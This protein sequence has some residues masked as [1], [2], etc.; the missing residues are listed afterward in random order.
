ML[1]VDEAL[2]KRAAEDATIAQVAR[3]RLFVG[4]TVAETAEVLDVLR[5]TGFRQWA[6]ARAWRAAALTHRGPIGP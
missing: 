3:L 2:A 4:L 1:A 6:Y 5:A